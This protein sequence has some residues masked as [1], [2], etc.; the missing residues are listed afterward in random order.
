MSTTRK[1]YSD[2]KFKSVF[3]VSKQQFI[4]EFKQ[5]YASTT[6]TTIGILNPKPSKK[7]K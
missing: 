2:K 7:K 6:M 1:P 5:A 4:D 3:G